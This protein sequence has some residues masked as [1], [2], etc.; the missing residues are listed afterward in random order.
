MGFIYKDV[1]YKHVPNKGLGLRKRKSPKMF[2]HWFYR[3]V[4][5]NVIGE[6]PSQTLGLRRREAKIQV[7]FGLVRILRYCMNL[8][9]L[10]RNYIF[11]K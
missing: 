10:K 1:E 2:F 9:F 4:K 11:N 6:S 7:A 5:A 8:P 3:Y